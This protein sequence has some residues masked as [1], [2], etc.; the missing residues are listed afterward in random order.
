MPPSAPMKPLSVFS[1]AQYDG[2]KQAEVSVE[3]IKNGWKIVA[4]GDSVFFI[5]FGAGVYFNGPEPYP[6]PG[7]RAFQDRRIWT[8]QGK[9]KH[10]G[11]L[12]RW[13]QFDFNSWH[14]AAMPMYHAERTME[15]EIKR[16][17][18]EGY[19]GDR[20]RKRDFDKVASRFFRSYP[21][22]SCYG[23]LVDTPANFP[24]LVLIEEDNAAYEGSLDASHREHNA[25]LL[26]SVNIYSNKISGAKQ[27][28]KAIM[29]LS[30]QKCKILDLPEFSAIK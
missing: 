15:Q 27:E 12:R 3:P 8:G 17:A 26:Y 30:T 6:E 13:R 1:R 7:R 28:C 2:E 24:C 18:R 23:E 11:L 25:T 16:I 9:A 21:S 4:S 10:L 20:R 19:S 22:G 5:E 29:E 14:S